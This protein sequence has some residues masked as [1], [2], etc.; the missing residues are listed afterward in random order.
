MKWIIVGAGALGAILAAHL[1]RSGE[2]VQLLAR[3]ARAKL[4]RETGVRL[5]GLV[6]LT[7]QVPIIE[8]PAALKD[9][10]V[11]VLTVK[12]YDT[13]T[14]LAPL[15]RVKARSAFSVQNGMLKN[16]QLADVFGRQAVIGS[17]ADFSGEVGTDGAVHFTRNE[18]LYVGELQGGISNR[19][20]T[21]AS[22]IEA[23]GVHTIASANIQTVEWSKFVGWLALTP[24]AVLTRLP[25]YRVLK[26]QDLMRLQTVL[27]RE[28]A[29]LANNL[30]IPLED[31]FGA[32]PSRTLVTAAV[33][34]WVAQAR[35]LGEV[36][37]AS[38]PGHKMSALQDLERG[39]RLEVEETFGYVVRKA[40]ELGIDMPAL[41]ACYRLLAGFGRSAG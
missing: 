34:D 41:D 30:S 4:L 7:A 13:E 11:L 25:T 19:V 5:S 29:Q 40:A 28:A 3:G 9:A 16:D 36:M 18:G 1:T 22:T 6:D 27:A 32:S 15:S 17:A 33:D 20:Q 31:L 38:I 21:I 39:R 14:A 8:D 35:L 23:A 10:D 12:T 2:D 37:E 24:L 26:D